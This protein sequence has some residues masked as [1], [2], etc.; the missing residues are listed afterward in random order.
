MNNNKY[1]LHYLYNYKI[2][3]DETNWDGLEQQNNYQITECNNITECYEITNECS[4]ITECYQITNECCKNINK[5][6]QYERTKDETIVVG[7]EL[8]N[9][10]GKL[11]RFVPR[12]VTIITKQG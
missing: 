4:N 8:P 10:Q 1:I 6:R 3:N 7:L 12:N 5:F 9:Q 11:I 2:K